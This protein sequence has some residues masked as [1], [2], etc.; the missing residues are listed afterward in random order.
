MLAVTPTAVQ[1]AVTKVA[2][3][4][5]AQTTQNHNV[6]FLQHS[7]AAIAILHLRLFAVWGIIIA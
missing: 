1:D 2:V 7:L 3:V 4:L 5:A 6:A